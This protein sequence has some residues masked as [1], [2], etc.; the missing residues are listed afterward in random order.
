MGSCKEVIASPGARWAR[1]RCVHRWAETTRRLSPNYFV[2]EWKEQTEK[3]Q[4]RR[5]IRGHCC[6]RAGD[7]PHL[8]RSEVSPGTK[9]ELQRTPRCHL[10]SHLSCLLPVS[11]RSWLVPWTRSWGGILQM[12]NF[13]NQALY[14]LAGQCLPKTPRTAHHHRASYDP[15]R[16]GIQVSGSP[17][18]S[19]FHCF[20][21]EV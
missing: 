11:R 18:Q 6:G 2:D 16:I 12:Q 14:L 9:A 17:G 1:N 3:C 20:M 5:Q 8:R 19:S 4:L 21:E 10:P 7:S 13:C 15:V